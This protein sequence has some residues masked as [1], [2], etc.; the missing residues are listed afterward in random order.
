MKEFKPLKWSNN[1]HSTT[2][3]Y[4]Q[5]KMGF[6]YANMMFS[7]TQ[8]NDM[9]WHFATFIGNEMEREVVASMEDGKRKAEEKYQEI[10]NSL[11]NS[12][13]ELEI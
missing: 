9:K 7:V 10:M 12:I 11:A 6:F 2:A 13:E 8:T 4:I 5:I 1:N 3:A